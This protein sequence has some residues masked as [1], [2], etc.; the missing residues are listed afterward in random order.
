[1]TR[2]D[3]NLAAP[4]SADKRSLLRPLKHGRN[5]TQ[6]V[7]ARIA[8]EI[9][10]GN[11]AAGTRLPTEQELMSALGVSRTVV[12]E[13][14]AA[15][16][17]DGLVVTRQGS[18]AYVANDFRRAA[19]R[20]DSDGAATL[21]HI[22]EVMELRVAV[23][24]EAAALAAERASYSKRRVIETALTAFARAV[25][26]GEN[27]IQ[28]DFALHQAIADATGNG[29]FS[30]FL[31]FLGRH[32]IPRQSIRTEIGT[33]AEQQAYLAQIEREHARIVEAIVEQNPAEARRAMR[34]HL[35]RSLQR[36]RGLAERSETPPK[37]GPTTHEGN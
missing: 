26:R 7:V 4:S 1:M 16:K 12:R 35:A 9:T 10:R 22:I 37:S 11:L 36:Y 14:V 20:I 8:D 31:T 32:V 6:E 18:G 28:E 21:G 3:Q 17:A 33:A 24:I 25:K 2:H 34:T 5:L 15:L 29:K 13:A 27:A 23:E 30:D 19:F